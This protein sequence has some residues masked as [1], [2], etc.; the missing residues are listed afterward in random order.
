MKMRHV[1]R[2]SGSHPC[3]GD[4]S[5]GSRLF[6][7]SHIIAMHLFFSQERWNKESICNLVLIGNNGYHGYL[8]PFAVTV[9]GTKRRSLRVQT[10]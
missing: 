4:G 1:S 10:L 8:N 9:V 3:W 5:P 7:L 6:H 2:F